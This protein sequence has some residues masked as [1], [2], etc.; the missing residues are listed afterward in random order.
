MSN[1]S[2]NIIC[3]FIIITILIV[4]FSSCSDKIK[5]IY[6]DDFIIGNTMDAIIEKYG[7]FDVTF[8]S[9]GGTYIST[10]GYIIKEV[11]TGYF[12]TDVYTYYMIRFNTDG[13]ATETWQEKGGWGG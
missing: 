1:R 10:A 11:K 8:T 2:R 6:D 5:S 12:G 13:I 7:D 9:G 4:S 3:R